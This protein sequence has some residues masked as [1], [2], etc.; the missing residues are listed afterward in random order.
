MRTA[1]VNSSTVKQFIED[2]EAFECCIG[3]SFAMLDVDGDGALS[4]EELRQGFGTVLPLGSVSEPRKEVVDALFEKIFQRFDSDGNGEIDP[5]EFR[6]LSK[7]MML[8]M[9]RGIGDS[10]VQLA[11]HRDSLLMRAVEHELGKI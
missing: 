8:A 11:V 2:E 10:P 3:R 1:I 9:A 6:S 5:E 7:E 4:R